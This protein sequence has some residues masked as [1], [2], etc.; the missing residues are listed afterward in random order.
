M[1]I[2]LGLNPHFGYQKKKI[3]VVNGKKNGLI[4]EN[5]DSK[6]VKVKDD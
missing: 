3:K 5:S 1:V 4:K 6:Q 2:T